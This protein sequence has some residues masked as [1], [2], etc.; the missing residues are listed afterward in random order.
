MQWHHPRWSG[1]WSYILL[2]DISASFNDKV[3]CLFWCF[4]WSPKNSYWRRQVKWFNPQRFAESYRWQPVSSCW[5]SPQGITKRS[6]FVSTQKKKRFSTSES[7]RL[8]VW[9]RIATEVSRCYAF[10]V[11]KILVPN[12]PKHM[13]TH[14]G[15]WYVL[16]VLLK[17]CTGENITM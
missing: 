9:R 1:L 5:H 8:K 16:V 4:T 3:L 14:E 2:R 15:F 6:R 7:K 10:E 17:G 11:K 12:L 13:S